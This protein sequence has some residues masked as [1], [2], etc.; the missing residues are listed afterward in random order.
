MGVSRE[1]MCL[2]STVGQMRDGHGVT[3]EE[4]TSSQVTVR[5]GHQEEAR[6]LFHEEVSPAPPF[7]SKL[8]DRK[9]LCAGDLCIKT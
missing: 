5:D 9:E 3:G 6:G 4:V 7:L 8:G 1:N 2:G